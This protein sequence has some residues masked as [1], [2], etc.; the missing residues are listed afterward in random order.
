MKM[1]RACGAL[2][3]LFAVAVISIAFADPTAD[4]SNMQIFMRQKLEFSKG[5]TEGIVLEKFEAISLNAAGL[6][7]MTQTNFWIQT[8]NTNYLA[9]MTNFQTQLDELFFAA[10]D[11]NLDRTTV[12]YGNILKSCVDCHHIVRKEQLGF[13]R[14]G[15]REE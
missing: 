10:G 3:V 7:K 11:R 8:Q 2:C 1:S 4:R 14:W 12:A 5:I 9:K 6:R 15:A 13:P